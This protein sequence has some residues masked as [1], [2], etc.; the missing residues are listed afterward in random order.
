MID[1]PVEVEEM[2]VEDVTPDPNCAAPTRGNRE[3]AP[4][5][6]EWKTTLQKK[7]AEILVAV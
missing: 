7:S 1:P 4:S 5:S 6:E 3:S 2:E